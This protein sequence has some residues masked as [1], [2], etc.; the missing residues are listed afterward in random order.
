MGRFLGIAILMILVLT[1]MF[2]LN[3]AV[4][5]LLFGIDMFD[6]LDALTSL[7]VA[8]SFPGQEAAFSSVN[9]GGQGIYGRRPNG[10]GGTN[11]ADDMTA[12]S[13]GVK[14]TG[15]TAR[16]SADRDTG[17]AGDS[18]GVTGEVTGVNGDD[19]FLTYDQICSLES[20][21]LQDKLKAVSILSGVDK[22]VLNS[23]VQMAEDG[24]TY[25]EYNELKDSAKEFLNPTDIETLEGILKRNIDLYAQGGK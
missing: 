1:V 13:P 2:I 22:D 15:A 17:A 10:A 12:V 18:S 20:M 21:S 8:G 5:W 3:S 14:V 11:A 25:D 6:Q 9:G 19:Y 4:L 24:V 16:N 23:A 7:V